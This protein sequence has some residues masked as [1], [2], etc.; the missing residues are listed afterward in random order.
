MIEK[1]YSVFDPRYDFSGTDYFVVGSGIGG[2]TAAIF[3]V[4]AGKKV[5][6]LEKHIVPGGFSHTFSRKNGFA[7]DVGVHYVG[8]M[9]DDSPLRKLSN[10]LT[11]DKLKWEF[12]GHTYDKAIFG[13]DEYNFISGKE[14]LKK[15]FH[16]Y[17]PEDKAAIDKY[18]EMVEKVSKKFNMFFIQKAFPA[19]LKKTAGKMIRKYLRKYYS[20]TTYEVLRKITSNEKL[21]NVLCSQCGNYGLPPKKSSFAVHAIVVNHF[22]D[23]GF[24]PSGGAGKIGENMIGVLKNNGGKVFVGAEVTDILTANNRVRGII[25][26]NTYIACNNV[27]SDAGASNTFKNLL[28]R[29]PDNAW[30]GKTRN[31]KPSHSHLCLYLGLDRPDA[32]LGLPRYNVWY[33]E[34][35]CIDEMLDKGLADI[36]GNLQF[37]Y[38][39]FP[40]AKDSSWKDKHKNS[41]TMQAIGVGNIDWFAKYKD[42]PSMKRGAEY[43]SLKERFKQ[44]M[45]ARLY[46]LFPG[47]KGH[48]AYA[49]VSTPLSTAHYTGCSS[50]EIYGLEHSPARFEQDYLCPETPIKGLYLTGI[51]ITLAGIGGAIISGILCASVILKFGIM[52]QFRQM[53]NPGNS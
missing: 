35:Y 36:D 5:V 14:N 13:K 10:Y 8:N 49:E 28:K 41:S 39:S 19:V 27:I 52:K 46:E 3:L 25:V 42:K 20:K 32:D 38:V 11:D 4:K 43:E 40:S 16:T 47:I 9:G 33:Y 23:G 44:K 31:I 21:I 30:A 29:N 7:W 18:F 26:N 53:A 2:L 48:I 34:K 45:L 24:Y 1:L 15:Q 50:G 17:F 22:I 6:V 12:M 51:D 37:A